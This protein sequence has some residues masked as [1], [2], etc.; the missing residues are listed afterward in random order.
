MDEISIKDKILLTIPEACLYSNIGKSKMRELL[1]TPCCDFVIMNGK[2]K[3]IKRQKF[4]EWLNEQDF[5]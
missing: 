5:L 3:L 1:N 2:K 4:E